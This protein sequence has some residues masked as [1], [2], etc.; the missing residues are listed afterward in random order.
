MALQ[1]GVPVGRGRVVAIRQ[2][3]LV[4]SPQWSPKHSA[5]TKSVPRESQHKPDPPGADTPHLP[6]RLATRQVV[7]DRRDRRDPDA[8]RDEDEWA[9]RLVEDHVTAGL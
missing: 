1:G 7:D 4:R 2:L 8:R 5:T 9:V 6:I 3:L